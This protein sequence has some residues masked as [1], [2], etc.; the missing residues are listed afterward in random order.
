MCSPALVTAL[1]TVAQARTTSELQSL[2]P[3]YGLQG[4]AMSAPPASGDGQPPSPKIPTW[5]LVKLEQ[6]IAALPDDGT[7]RAG[8][9]VKLARLMVARSG[10]SGKRAADALG[11]A[12]VRVHRFFHK[13]KPSQ[14]IETAEE[15][16]AI[17]GL[18]RFRFDAES[19]LAAQA[20]EVA[21]QNPAKVLEALERE[22]QAQE[23]IQQAVRN[24]AVK[25]LLESS[26]SGEESTGEHETLDDRA[27]SRTQDQAPAVQLP[28]AH[29]DSR[30]G[31]RGRGGAG[32][33][34]AVAAKK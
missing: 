1:V 14:T 21:N 25:K 27:I 18:P 33:G 28:P 3:P 17:L 8:L 16:R 11:A 10:L 29:A 20:M 32:A 9:H 30:S 34:A 15:F 22:A 12:K 23:R 31:Q 5:W 6:S 2:Y 19:E 13:T 7:G 24:L 4:F 26:D